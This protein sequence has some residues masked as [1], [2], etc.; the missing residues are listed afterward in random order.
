[1]LEISNKTKYFKIK[2][3]SYVVKRNYRVIYDYHGQES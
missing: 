2:T 3:S 1:M